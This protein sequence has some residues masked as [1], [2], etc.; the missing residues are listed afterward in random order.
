M[1]VSKL[2][3]QI[4]VFEG[5]ENKLTL[6]QTHN[7]KFH[8]TYLLH[9]YPFDTQICRVDL[10]LEKFSQRNVELVPDQINLLTDT[11]LTQYYIQTWSLDYNDPG[12]W[13][14]LFLTLFDNL[15]DTSSILKTNSFYLSLFDCVL[16]FHTIGAWLNFFAQHLTVKK[17]Q[18]IIDKVLFNIHFRYNN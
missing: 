17:L 2:N 14:L 9:Y 3:V 10:Q 4:E 13:Y 15:K 1:F 16:V 18:I 6:N 12:H 8:C 5:E 11:E 7:K